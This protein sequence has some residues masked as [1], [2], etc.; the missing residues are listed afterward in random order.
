MLSSF[1]VNVSIRCP[2]IKATDGFPAPPFG[3]WN[4]APA[5][6]HLPQ[7][8]IYVSMYPTGNS[9]DRQHQF[10][11]GGVC[12]ETPVS[13]PFW[14]FP[15]WPN[16]LA[17]FSHTGNPILIQAAQAECPVSGHRNALPP[18]LQQ[19]PLPSASHRIC[20]PTPPQGCSSTFPGP[21][22]AH[23]PSLPLSSSLLAAY[24]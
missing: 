3:A 13:F 23:S 21:H 8:F 6:G 11:D 7:W 10:P 16:Q 22:G 20:Q 9:S 19:D 15:S 17:I 12:P 24:I 1:P 2:Y 14:V 18:P 4:S 5:H